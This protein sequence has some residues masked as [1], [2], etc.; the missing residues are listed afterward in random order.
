MWIGTGRNCLF[1]QLII[2]YDGEGVYHSSDEQCLKD[3]EKE[4][5]AV[6]KGYKFLRLSKQDIKDPEL[7]VRIKNILNNDWIC[8][9]SKFRIS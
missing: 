5:F 4:T 7:I 9:N 3:K 8:R 1:G 6:Q 2:E